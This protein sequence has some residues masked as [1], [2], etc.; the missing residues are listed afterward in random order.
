MSAV[1]L[2]GRANVELRGCIKFSRG[3]PLRPLRCE[4]ALNVDQHPCP[5]PWLTLNP[6][7]FVNDGR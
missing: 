1:K 7:E 5:T 2:T 3:M 4:F 6:K